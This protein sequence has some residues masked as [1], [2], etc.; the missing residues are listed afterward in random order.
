[1]RT[2]DVRYTS[3]RRGMDLILVAGLWMP[4]SVWDDVAHELTTLG[5]RPVPLPLPGVDDDRRSVTLDDQL[6]AL[7]EAVD[8][9]PHPY[10][11][12]HSAAAGLAWLAADRRPEAVSGVALV[13]G[14]PNSDGDVYADLFPVEDG[15]M[16]F[17]GWD[18]F[19]GPDAADLD[20]ATRERLAAS[21][22]PVPEGV[23]K[24]VVRLRDERRF[25]LP[26]TL[27][28]PEF[29]PAQARDW[30]AGGDL[31]ELERVER[32]SYVDLDSGHW[33]MV[34]RPVELA[35]VLA[36]AAAATRAAA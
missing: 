8:A 24:G 20:A 11:V 33:P 1:M 35:R 12:G 9:A 10:V 25:G 30:V 3:Y 27:V 17:P 34:T 16:P 6:D 13:G 7:L 36:E 19:E 31:P 23:S 15:A 26:V 5:H 32:L 2:G 14:F 21:A 28:C 29:S 18:P 22:R 4:V